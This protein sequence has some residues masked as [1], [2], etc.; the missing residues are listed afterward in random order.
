MTLPPEPPYDPSSPEPGVGPVGYGPGGFGQPQSQGNGLAI[1]SLATG[2]ASVV[3]GLCCLSPFFLL[4]P[5]AIV[6]GLR[7]QKRSDESRGVVGG[8]RMATAGLILGIIGSVLLLLEAGW[9]V[10][11]MARGGDV[12][13][14]LGSSG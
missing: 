11:L 14:Q 10:Y 9:F 6:L 13:F 8:R 4:A 3:L 7:G 1:A 2:S 12:R 5:V